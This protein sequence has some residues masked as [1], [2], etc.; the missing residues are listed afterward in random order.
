MARP[1]C[2]PEDPVHLWVIDRAIV[3]APDV[4]REALAAEELPYVL[5]PVIGRGARP[6]LVR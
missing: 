1:S 4:T 5:A 2:I 6:R 3:D